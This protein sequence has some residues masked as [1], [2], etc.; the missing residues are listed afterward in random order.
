MKRLKIV[1]RTNNDERTLKCFSTANRQ[2]QFVNTKGWA[3]YSYSNNY[4]IIR[5][6]IIRQNIRIQIEY[7]N[8]TVFLFKK[9]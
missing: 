3:E 9:K 7:K 2:T 5:P 4:S 1:I 8:F 6:E